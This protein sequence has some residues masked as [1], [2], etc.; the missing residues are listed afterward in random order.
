MGLE[1]IT[2]SNGGTDLL[3][4]WV[5]FHPA[6]VRITDPD[7][8]IFVDVG[9]RIYKQFLMEIWPTSHLWEHLSNQVTIGDVVE[10]VLGRIII[11]WAEAMTLGNP[12]PHFVDSP[13]CIRLKRMSRI[14]LAA[15]CDLYMYGSVSFV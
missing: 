10:A 14:C 7:T 5:L 1:A 4:E 13:A 8:P 15:Y 6:A 11:D 9:N 2:L 3:G 12:T